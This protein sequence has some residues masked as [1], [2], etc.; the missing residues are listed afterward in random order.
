MA[1]NYGIFF[2]IISFKQNANKSLPNSIIHVMFQ[3]TTITRH[4]INNLLINQN[5][6]FFG[7][8]FYHKSRNEFLVGE[9][10]KIV[11]IERKTLKHINC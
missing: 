10:V 6:F 7:G 11:Y 2:S 5:V 4:L 1:I 8:Y 9:I 3:W